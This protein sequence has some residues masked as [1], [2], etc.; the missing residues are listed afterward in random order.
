MRAL[1]TEFSIPI[2]VY[3]EDTDAGGIVYYVNY[4]KFMERVRTEFIRHLGFQHNKL[5]EENLLFV[6]HSADVKYLSPARID[7]QLVSVLQ[8]QALGKA[9]IVFAQQVKRADTQQI[10]CQ[11]IIKVA[12][13]NPTT[14]KPRSISPVLAEA[15]K[16]YQ[17]EVTP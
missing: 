14:F 3:I 7:Q 13:V 1:M 9:S 6:V 12:C 10:L 4:L 17:E 2:R 16:R 11:A 8:I 15:L 5:M